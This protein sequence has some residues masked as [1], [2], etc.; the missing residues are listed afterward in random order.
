V[1]R[2]AET[3]PKIHWTFLLLFVEV[4]SPNEK[5]GGKKGKKKK[6]NR[7]EKTRKKKLPVLPTMPIFS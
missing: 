7:K 4:K 2:P 3:T 1:L 6:E 5:G